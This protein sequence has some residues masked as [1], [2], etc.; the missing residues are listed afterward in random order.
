[1]QLFAT[2]KQRAVRVLIVEDEPMI[3]LCLEDV[4]IDA[5]FEVAGVVEN[6]KKRWR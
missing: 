3:A 5:D 4:L 6:W 2:T 1:M